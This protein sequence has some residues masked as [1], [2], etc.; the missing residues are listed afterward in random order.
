MP[1]VEHQGAMEDYNMAI[2]LNPNNALAYK[3]RASLRRQ[4]GDEQGAQQDLDKAKEI[5]K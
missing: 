5:G 3:N 4:L 2:K 1:Q